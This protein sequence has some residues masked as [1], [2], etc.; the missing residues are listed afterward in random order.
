MSLP[1]MPSVMRTF[2]ARKTRKAGRCKRS[3][4]ASEMAVDNRRHWNIHQNRL[5][6]TQETKP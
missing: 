3:T 1:R 5:Y 6:Q 4:E 2:K